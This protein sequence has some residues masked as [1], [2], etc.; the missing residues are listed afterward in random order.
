MINNGIFFLLKAAVQID[1]SINGQRVIQ[2]DTVLGRYCFAAKRNILGMALICKPVT[3]VGY[4]DARL[5]RGH[6]IERL[7]CSMVDAAEAYR[8]DY[9][10]DACDLVVGKV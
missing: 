1:I 5:G 6:V 7:F 4:D 3:F 10:T 2:Y 9:D 8:K